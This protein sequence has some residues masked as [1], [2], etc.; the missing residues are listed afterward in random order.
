MHN[1]FCISHWYILSKT[2]MN[3]NSQSFLISICFC[4]LYLIVLDW[5][6]CQILY[7]LFRSIKIAY[8]LPPKFQ[9]S[10]LNPR[11][12]HQ[13]II[14]IYQK[15]VLR[16]C[17]RSRMIFLCIISCCDVRGALISHCVR[18]HGVPS[19]HLHRPPHHQEKS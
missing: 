1:A 11:H 15:I 7:K 12:Y 2:L 9:K 19:P 13:S 18:I 16:Q 10:F 8:V 5:F 3:Q 6:Y 17:I 4:L 14:V